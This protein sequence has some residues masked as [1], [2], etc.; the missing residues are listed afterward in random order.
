MAAERLTRNTGRLC[1]GKEGPTNVVTFPLGP[2]LPALVQ[3]FALTVKLRGETV[4]V[5]DPPHAGYCARDI[6]TLA[7]G[8]SIAQALA[9]VERS[10]ALSGHTHRTAA[11]QAIEDALRIVPSHRANLL[12]AAFAEIERVLARLWTLGLCARAVEAEALWRAA[13]EQREMLFAALYQAT[14]QRSFW[15][16]AQPGGV[17]AFEP[18]LDSGAL[19]GALAR[20]EPAL[21][22]WHTATSP[23]GWLYR[24]AVGA[25]ML[26]EARVRALE[27]KG[28][29]ARAAGLDDDLRRDAPDDAYA[30]VA[31]V[32]PEE[33]E[34]PAHGD[35]AARLAVA[36][37]DLAI[38][39]RLARGLLEA[40]RDAED[41]PVVVDVAAT[42][43]PASDLVGSATR[44]GPHGPVT[45]TLAL[46]PE[47]VVDELRLRTPLAG[48]WAALPEMLR[49]QPVARAPLIV[50][51]LDLCVECLDL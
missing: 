7:H 17:R 8:K 51:S 2:Y 11:C 36:V 6:V 14:G 30:A 1:V 27:V 26:D 24:A 38:S 18:P 46:A 16:V 12:R 41:A 13:L 47:G 23:G 39:V 20:L 50:A 34:H 19:V 22:S 33:R 35:A 3:P 48:T 40:A 32:W 9:L 25:G 42:E 28:L 10:C 5:V 21:V 4:D 49:G 31:D 15:G 44:E 37:A 29:A 45:V 43:V